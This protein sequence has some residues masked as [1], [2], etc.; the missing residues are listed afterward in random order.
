[1]VDLLGGNDIRLLVERLGIVPTKKLGQ[2]FVTDPNTIR[3]IVAAAKLD[4]DETVVEIGPGL[5]SLTLGLLESVK[6]VIAVEI[7]PKMAA[8]LEDTVAARAPGTVFQLVRADAMKVTELPNAPDA[9]V[10]NLPYNISV[11]VLLHFL[12]TFSSLEKGLVLVQAE[13]AHR[14][15]ATPGSKIYG[16]PS[17]K[18]AWYAESALAGNVGRNIFWPVPNV[19]SA[20]VYFE[21]RQKPLGDEGLRLR[22]FEIADAAFSQRRKT[23]RQ[24]L[25]GWAGDAAN[26]ER[27]LQL[28]GVS[29][30][31]RGEELSVHDFVRIAEVS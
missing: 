6:K 28:A 14:L 26:A 5:G 1:M 18:L 3:R 13:V 16:I 15:A 7:D 10:A 12:E 19:D 21:K 9:L 27:L 20:L 25:S 2:N 4:G 23:L 24:A 17:V 29:P 31:A 30:Q 8:E 11:P 22:T